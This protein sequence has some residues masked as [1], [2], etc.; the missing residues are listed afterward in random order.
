[1]NMHPSALEPL[2]AGRWNRVAAAHLLNRAGFGV[3]PD[4]VEQAADRGLAATVD[5][6]LEFHRTP[7]PIP[8]PEWLGPDADRRPDRSVLQGLSEEE[9]RRTQAELRR[10]EAQRMLELRGW[11]LER[12][13]SGPYPLQEKLTLCWHGHFATSRAKV[14]SAYA[15]WR[16]NQTLREHAAGNWRGMLKAV[17]R[18]PAMLIW[19]DNARSRRKSPN[20]NY[21]RELMELF[22][23]GEGHYSETDI[24]EAAR[25]FT[26]WTLDTGRFVFR[27]RPPGHD[28]GVKTV[29]GVTGRLDGDG[30]IDAILARPQAA[31]H[32]ARRLWEYFVSPDP[33]PPVVDALAS[34]IRAESYELEPTLRALFSSRAFHSERVRRAHVKSPVHW[35][36][37]TLRMLDLPLPPP[38]RCVN[39]LQTLGQHLFEPP[40]VKGWDGGMAWITASSLLSRYRFAE[41][42]VRQSPGDFRRYLP[43]DVRSLTWGEF[44]RRLCVRV[45]QEPLRPED[46]SE[47]VTR[48]PPWP[49]AEWGDAE[50]RETLRA[51]LC[52]VHY[53]LV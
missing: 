16:Q 18:D 50:V 31:T 22:T 39:A 27:N 17:S 43:P 7:P 45:F 1:M 23:L 2:P 35:L 41:E 20:E 37:G 4:E 5:R 48:L 49:P 53:Q 10:A 40:N 33:D 46:R 26:G 34:V 24:R 9:R 44:M 47:L 30:V 32:L 52:T 36:V 25:A 19:L 21:A 3:R 51:L 13:R 29:L 42:L 14:N 12:M 6:L 15:M 38:R 11:W 8:P 28:P